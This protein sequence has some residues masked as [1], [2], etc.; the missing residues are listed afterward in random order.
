MHAIGSITVLSGESSTRFHVKVSNNI[1]STS[2]TLSKVW[3][4]QLKKEVLWSGAL[5]LHVYK[6]PFNFSPGACMA[7]SFVCMA[8]Y[9]LLQWWLMYTWMD[10]IS[11]H[12][13][14]E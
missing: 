14:I 11:G 2:K 3:W 9:F 1:T 8:L 12:A 5:S 6:I 13:M 7:K 4:K 10:S